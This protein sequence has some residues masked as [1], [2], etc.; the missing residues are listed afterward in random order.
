MKECFNGTFVIVVGLF[1]E[2]WKEEWNP[3]GRCLQQGL[4][5]SGMKRPSMPHLAA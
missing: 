2:E 5:S 1:K 3:Q 4:G